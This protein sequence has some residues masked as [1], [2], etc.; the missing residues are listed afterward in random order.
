VTPM[1]PQPPPEP[2]TQDPPGDWR[3]L[4][5][6]HRGAA[7]DRLGLPNQDAVAVLESGPCA[8]TV[9]VADGHGHHRHFRSARGSRLAVAVACRVTPEFTAS[10]IPLAGAADAGQ[11]IRQ[12]LVP[13]LTGRWR[14]AV[15]DDLAAEPFTAAEEPSRAAGDDPL[16]AYGTTLLVAAVWGDWL[17]LAQI[18]DG[19]IV[20]IRPDGGALL[21]VPGDPLL[22][23]RHTTSLCSPAAEHSFR[24]AAVNTADTALLG[25][26]L[27][28][29]GYGNAQ[30]TEAWENAVSADLAGL[31]AAHPP[32][33]L[34]GQL[35]AWTARCASAGGSADD[36]TIA[37]LLAPGAAGTGSEAGTGDGAGGWPRQEPR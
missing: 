20:G 13:A 18:G 37:L 7:H 16:I 21:P 25:V 12:G 3:I 24:V 35:P 14:E 28:T 4:T 31:I 6:T 19:D 17:L 8:A 30:A 29:D 34:A 33:W 1:E 27:A 11:R 2:V 5:A 32:D 22:D 10:L 36:T 23:G 9:A 26:L 15:L